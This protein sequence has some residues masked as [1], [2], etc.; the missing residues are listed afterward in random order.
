MMKAKKNKQFLQELL[1]ARGLL[2]RQRETIEQTVGALNQSR[3]IIDSAKEV[4]GKVNALAEAP[5]TEQLVRS[6]MKVELG[7]RYRKIKTVSLH[8]NSEKNLILR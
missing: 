3:S 6:V 4:A 7:M 5:V 1:D 2:D 8:S